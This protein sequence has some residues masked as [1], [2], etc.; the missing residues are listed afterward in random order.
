MA[1]VAIGESAFGHF[2]TDSYSSPT[3]LYFYPN[4]QCLEAEAMEVYG[5]KD[6]DGAIVDG[7]IADWLQGVSGAITFGASNPTVEEDGDSTSPFHGRL[8]L[9]FTIA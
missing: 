9:T 5:K 6:D 8:R 1:T 2:L 7:E 3:K 4:V